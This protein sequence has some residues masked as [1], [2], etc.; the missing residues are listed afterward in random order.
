MLMSGRII[1]TIF[2]KGW[3]TPGFVPPPTSWSFDI[4]LELLQHLWVCPFIADW[5]L[6]SR[7]VY[8]LGPNSVQHLSRVWLF[9]TPWPA[10]RQASFHH[11][12]PELTQTHVHWVGDVI[13]PPH[14]LSSP[15]PPAFNLSQH[16][17][18]FQRVRSLHQ[19]TK[20]LKL[21][22]QHQSFQWIFRTDFL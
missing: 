20:V 21:Q 5:G 6:R 17:G 11:Q 15:S 19:V 2:G 8:H 10:A 9:V 14:P 3:R 4:A 12:L 18:L 22:L 13:Q 7:F 16:Q 1:P